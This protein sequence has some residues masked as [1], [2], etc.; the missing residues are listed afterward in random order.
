M[1]KKTLEMARAEIRR[2][3]RE[4]ADPIIAE[5]KLV[6]EHLWRVQEEMMLRGQGRKTGDHIGSPLPARRRGMIRG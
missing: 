2:M 5:I 1:D 6:S 4:A 3:V